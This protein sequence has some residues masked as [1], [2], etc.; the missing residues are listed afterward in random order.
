MNRQE[1]LDQLERM[2]QKLS[3]DIILWRRRDWVRGICDPC[4]GC[5]TM[6]EPEEECP[7]CVAR[8]NK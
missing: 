5:G 6:L 8:Q 1:N 7:I 3:G 4:P 2:E